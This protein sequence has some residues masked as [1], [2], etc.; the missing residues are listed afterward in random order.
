MQR[1]YSDSATPTPLRPNLL[2]LDFLNLDS[3]NETKVSAATSVPTS[4]N[5]NGGGLGVLNL[6][7]RRQSTFR[8]ALDLG[9]LI[10]NTVQKAM[11]QKNGKGF[12][13]LIYRNN[14]T[15]K[16]DLLQLINDKIIESGQVL[17]SYKQIEISD[18][19]L[20]PH[21][22]SEDLNNT[23][24][25]GQTA[26]HLAAQYCSKSV[27]NKMLASGSDPLKR[28]IDGLTPSHFAAIA[29]NVE[30]F[31]ELPKA[32]HT[33]VDSVGCRMP[34]HYAAICGKMDI[35]DMLISYA[36][37]HIDTE[38]GYGSTPLVLAAMYGHPT[39]AEELIVRGASGDVLN[40]NQIPAVT[41][42]NQ[43]YDKLGELMLDRYKK[44]DEYSN[45][46]TV[47]LEPLV[48]RDINA[49]N[50][51]EQYSFYQVMI[52]TASNDSTNHPV[53]RELTDKKWNLYAQRRFILQLI[54]LAM[55]NIF[56]T[57]IYVWPHTHGSDK[58][59]RIMG[60]VIM[61]I[62]GF[63][64][65]AHIIVNAYIVIK[66]K[67]LNNYLTKIINQ[68][69]EF[70]KAAK[71]PLTES[72]FKHVKTENKKL[73]KRRSFVSTLVIFGVKC[74]IDSLWM[75]FLGMRVNAFLQGD[76]DHHDEGEGGEG[77]ETEPEA[78][79]YLSETSMYLIVSDIAV[80]ILL[81][82][83]WIQLFAACSISKSVGRFVVFTREV[84]RD[85][86][87]VF[88]VYVVLFIPMTAIFWKTIY[89]HAEAGYHI[90]WYDVPFVVLRMLVVDYD[91]EMGKSSA[92]R[93]KIGPWWDVISIMWLLLSAMI[94]LNLF[95]ALMTDR[96]TRL[97]E[98]AMAM[99]SLQRA[100]FVSNCDCIMGRNAV[101]SYSE[102][103]LRDSPVVTIQLE[104][105]NHQ[106]EDV[107]NE[108]KTLTEKID[109]ISK[110]LDQMSGQSKNLNTPSPFS[111]Q[112][113]E[114]QDFFSTKDNITPSNITKI[115]KNI[116]KT[117]SEEPPQVTPASV[118]K[119]RGLL[120]KSQ[121]LKSPR[122]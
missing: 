121:S 111:R 10:K 18:E 64:I 20:T 69:Y 30:T 109:E 16:N 19:E 33:M 1:K 84:V 29:G 99:C 47:N 3:I 55:F 122:S 11:V 54:V 104:H 79:N 102:K 80:S 32:C 38:D 92:E 112:T 118:N 60:M 7:T 113:S 120:S 8:S 94:M 21:L 49:G 105:E 42:V 116:S 115:T 74:L 78:D 98:G 39:V 12:L 106:H 70:E 23:D 43:F 25:R 83:I 62:G 90:F 75:T 34:I 68:A 81:I 48:K 71:H 93:V 82:M 61:F 9:D 15:Q 56:W 28:D 107:L 86:A 14:L 31:G 27:L 40:R 89:T 72:S 95:I 91:Y 17:G 41:V 4:P 46:I 63:S 50:S 73:M 26:L 53:I 57:S 66:K 51:K 59:L 36:N 114:A 35:M 13:Q 101:R 44:Y 96:Y 77:N 37:Q 103:I 58:H 6:K 45:S 76:A 88:S 97:G 65:F 22:K 119:F 24:A 2:N 85:V 5:Q 117:N 52:S 108:V 87:Q 100:Q 110:K 67:M